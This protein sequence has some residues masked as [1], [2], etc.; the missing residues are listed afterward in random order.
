MGEVTY[1]STLE[2][3]DLNRVKDVGCYI[4]ENAALCVLGIIICV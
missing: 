4:T 2:S 3:I 1:M